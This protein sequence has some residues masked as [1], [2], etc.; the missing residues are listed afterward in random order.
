MLSIQHFLCRPQRRPPSKV[1]ARWLFLRLLKWLNK[2]KRASWILSCFL[3]WR[4]LGALAL[5][6]KPKSSLLILAE[7]KITRCLFVCLFVFCFPNAL[8]KLLIIFHYYG[9]WLLIDLILAVSFSTFSCLSCLH[10]F[11]FLSFLPSVWLSFFPFLN[12][13]LPPHFQSTQMFVTVLY[14]MSKKCVSTPPL[15]F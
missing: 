10:P 4:Y 12:F 14:T 8:S 6:R 2:D 15:C 13:C 5:N 7:K 9:C 3:Q 11:S 1:L